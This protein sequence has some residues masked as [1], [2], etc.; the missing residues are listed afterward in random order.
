[1]NLGVVLSLKAQ[2]P[3]FQAPKK[4]DCSLMSRALKMLGNF[5]MWHAIMM[6]RCSDKKEQ[7][8]TRAHH[9][10]ST[11]FLSPIAFLSPNETRGC[12][13]NNFTSRFVTGVKVISRFSQNI[14]FYYHPLRSP[15]W[16]SCLNNIW[17][18]VKSPFLNPW[19]SKKLRH[20]F[21]SAQENFLG[22]NHPE[23]WPGLSR[24]KYQI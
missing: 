23:F 15:D 14:L 21:R 22:W 20:T 2:K 19:L 24:T 17:W 8:K 16:V 10:I 11:C 13:N 4:I 6:R 3:C 12:L 18:W 1:M 9:Q 5:V 7:N